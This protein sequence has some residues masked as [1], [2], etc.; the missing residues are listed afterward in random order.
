MSRASTILAGVWLAG[1]TI[2]FVDIVADLWPAVG[3]QSDVCARVNTMTGPDTPEYTRAIKKAYKIACQKGD[4]P[5]TRVNVEGMRMALSPDQALYAIV[6]LFAGIGGLL[7]SMRGLFSPPPAGG[8]DTQ[9][10]AW[11]LVRPVAA[12]ALGLIVYVIARAMF[13]PA[14]NLVTANPY[15]FLALA[16]LTGLFTDTILARLRSAGPPFPANKS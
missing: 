14:G 8:Q 10:M 7:Q 1:L 11:A 12:A 2:I 5:I 13:L 16:A 6:A 4:T 15:G 9:S 3:V